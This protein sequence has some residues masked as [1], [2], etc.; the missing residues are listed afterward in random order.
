[1]FAG[2]AKRKTGRGKLQ[3]KS[4]GSTFRTNLNIL[5]EKLNSTGS[6]FIRCIKP[7]EKMAPLEFNGAS[8]MS[9]LH[10]AGIPAVLELMQAGYPSRTQFSD[11]YGMYKKHM[12]A[13]LSKLDPKLFT[14]ALFQALG[15]DTNDFTY[16][17][18][19]VFFKPGKFAAFDQMMNG[20]PEHLREMLKKVEQWLIKARWR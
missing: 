4:N 7:N 19:K 18:S 10:S 13:K 16:G 12:P 14:R 17:V 9:Q 20:D 6:S 1:M 8:I 2:D 5:M 3:L 11:L 15:L